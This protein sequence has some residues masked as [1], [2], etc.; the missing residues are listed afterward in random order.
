MHQEVVKTYSTIDARF[1]NLNVSGLAFNGG[2]YYDFPPLPAE[3]GSNNHTRYTVDL[4]AH[5]ALQQYIY[6]AMQGTVY[7]SASQPFSNDLVRGIWNGTSDPD[8]WINNVATS[9]TNVVRS[10]NASSRPQY[11]GTVLGLAVQVRW[12]WLAFPA[13]LVLMS[14]VFLVMVMIRTAHSPIQS[15]KGSPLTLLLFDIDDD[16]RKLAYDKVNIHHGVRRAMGK[17]RVKLV[18]EKGGIR[19]FHAL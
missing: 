7:W 13:A 15:W 16:T 12:E 8:V 10:T 3:I 17:T 11:D 1:S 5:L 6:R 9:L 18:E 14:I 2:T 19:K 4:W